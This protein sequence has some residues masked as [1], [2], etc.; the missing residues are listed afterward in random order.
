MG[1]AIMLDG[2]TNG[3]SHT[4]LNFLVSFPRGAMFLKS[5]EECTQLGEGCTITIE[6]FNE[7]Y[8]EVE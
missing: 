7:I 4:I 8:E 1:C 2:W 6:L 5:S 3:R